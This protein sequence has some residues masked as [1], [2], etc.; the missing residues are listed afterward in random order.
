M[1]LRKI[2][3]VKDPSFRNDH[4]ILEASE[5]LTWYW[6]VANHRN[7]VNDW[8][9]FAGQA[10]SISDSVAPDG[11]YELEMEMQLIS[12]HGASQMATGIASESVEDPKPWQESIEI[13]EADETMEILRDVAPPSRETTV[14]GTLVEAK[15]LAS[16]GRDLVRRTV[17]GLVVAKLKKIL[18]G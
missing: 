14:E 10:R 2:T 6:S 8:A 4:N 15:V 7:Q 3:D 13:P 16:L 1:E 18:G 11:L 9:A 17:E 12:D 5:A